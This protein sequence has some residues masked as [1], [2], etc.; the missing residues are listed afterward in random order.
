MLSIT[1]AASSPEKLKERKG[2][3][4]SSRVHP[5]E[6]NSSWMMKGFIEFIL[7]ESQDAQFLRENF[8][9]RLIPM[10]NPDGVIVGNHRCN[11]TGYDLNRQWLKAE[12]RKQLVPEIFHIKDMLSKYAQE[13]EIVLFCDLHGHNRKNG[14]FIYGCHNDDNQ[15]RKYME[16]VFPYMLSQNAPKLFYFKRCKFKIQKS[17]EGTGRIT[18]WRMLNIVNSFTM[19]ASFCGSDTH[20]NQGFHYNTHDLQEIGRK[21]GKTLF[22]Y[23]ISSI[24]QPSQTPTDQVKS[25]I[26]QAAEEPTLERK[27][28]SVK[29][30]QFL[31]K[32][33]N[34]FESMNVTVLPNDSGSSDSD[35]SS[36]DEVLRI[37]PKKSKKKKNVSPIVPSRPSSALRP[38]S[39]GGESAGS[40]EK[41]QNPPPVKV[42]SF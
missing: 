13:R 28:M 23:F 20:L 22:D 40:I 9:I 7:G 30:Y 16:R 19:E 4:I 14:I 11:L 29:A 10:L 1:A 2:I 41:K 39:R 35:T 33:R 31:E 25:T 38:P 6:T 3:I 5:G 24:P 21:L 34:D 32:L 36:D 18:I 27:E 42:I 8:V 17:K 37:K 26:A 15:E 12:S